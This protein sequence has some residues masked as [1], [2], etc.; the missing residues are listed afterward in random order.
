MTNEDKKNALQ[1]FVTTF[2]P[3]LDSIPFAIAAYDGQV[4]AD[5]AVI[6][7]GITD[8]VAVALPQAVAERTATLEA[9]KAALIG[10]KTTLESANATLE[11]EKATLESQVAD[12]PNQIAAATAPLEATIAEKETLLA[13]KEAR[14][15]EL[16]AAAQPATGEANIDPAPAEEVTP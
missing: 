10:E 13:E 6:A 11:T 7:Q 16:E 14:V 5:Q 4:Q 1:S 15:A 3:L 2:Q 9:E 8:G 12:I